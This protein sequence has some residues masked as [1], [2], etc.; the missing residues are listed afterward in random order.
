MQRLRVEKWCDFCFNEKEMY[1]VSSSNYTIS[2]SFQGKTP[3]VRSVD[4]CDKHDESIQ[5]FRAIVAK[6]GSSTA[7]SGKSSTPLAVAEEVEEPKL[8]EPKP[9]ANNHRSGTCPE[10]GI[11]MV[12]GVPAHL[13]RIH[14]IPQIKQPMRCPDCEYTASSENGM[15]VHRVRIHDYDLAA[16]M[17]AHRKR[18]KR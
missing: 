6:I 16:D 9:N 10:C 3:L 17:Y 4:A 18:R 11:H 12:G 1:V 2:I 15:R 8:E 7:R 5:G 13:A 14:G